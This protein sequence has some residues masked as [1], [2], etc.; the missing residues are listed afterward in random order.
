[1]AKFIEYK[2]QPQPWWDTLLKNCVLM[3]SPLLAVILFLEGVVSTIGFVVIIA[4]GTV[5]FFL[6]Y[7]QVRRRWGIVPEVASTLPDRP[8]KTL[9]HTVLEFR[10][11]PDSRIVATVV[12]VC[13]V[14]YIVTPL[15]LI[16]TRHGWK[17]GAWHAGCFGLALCPTIL[18]LAVFWWSLVSLRIEGDEVQVIHPLLRGWGNRTFRFGEIARVEVR[19]YRGSHLLRIHLH[20]GSSVGYRTWDKKKAGE[21]LGVLRRGVAEAKPP[22]F[23]LGELA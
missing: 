18:A 14:P 16:Y 11:E 9:D 3:V 10:E 12:S 6:L 20:N 17:H 5:V 8:A 7:D 1:V 15:I 4:C 19:V 21:L 13:A 22:P 2:S 23:D